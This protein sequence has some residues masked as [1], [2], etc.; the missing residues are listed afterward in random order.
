[1]QTADGMKQTFLR[2]QPMALVILR[3]SLWQATAQPSST[4]PDVQAPPTV[5]LEPVENALKNRIGVG[6]LMGLNITVDF[7]HLGGLQ[8]SDP[9]PSTGSRFNRNYDDGYN[10]V[11]SS[12]NNGGMTWNWGYTRSQSAQGNDVVLQSYSTPANLESTGN[13]DGPDHG[14]ELLYQRELRRE[15][16]WR[17]GAG[18][19]LGYNRISISDS[20][21][22]VNSSIRTDDSFSL[23]GST[24]PLPPYHGTF[25]GPGALMNSTPSRSL[26]TLPGAASVFG[27]RSIVTDLFTVRLGPYLEFP[28]N[29]KWTLFA[30]GGLTL[31]LAHTTFSFTE[32]VLIYDPQYT[33]HLIG[34]RSRSGSETDFMVGG[35]AGMGI[36][37]ALTETVNLFGAARFQAA[38]TAVN[39]QG[40][41]ESALHLN[42]SILVSIGISYS[43]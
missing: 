30:D 23:N 27:E 13:S 28:L 7:R 21:S 39:R 40:G 38:G 26:T 19:A 43:F 4:A 29:E 35:Y 18:A 11:D 5:K 17:F 37:F 14:L 3:A 31:G 25:E 33:V 24:P 42:Q 41:K 8:L 12:T 34:T 9:G 10:R 20:A 15:K 6:Y 36:S 1:M 16:H 2:L 22:F 32:T